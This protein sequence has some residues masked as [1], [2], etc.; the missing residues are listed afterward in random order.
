MHQTGYSRTEADDKNASMPHIIVKLGDKVVKNHPITQD[1]VSIGRARDNDIILEN[2][3]VSRNHA[4]IR[5]EGTQIVLVDLNSANGIFVNGVRVSRAEL[6]DGDIVSIGKHRLHFFEQ[7]Q[8][9]SVGPGAAIAADPALQSEAAPP[10]RSKRRK[11]VTAVPMGTPVPDLE[12]APAAAAP[13]ANETADADLFRRVEAGELIAV[14]EVK[15]GRQ[16]GEAFRL[17]IGECVIGRHNCAVRLHD[18]ATARQHARISMENPRFLL[19]D[20]GSWQGTTVNGE[21]VREKSLHPGDEIFVGTTTL[22]FAVGEEAEL[23]TRFTIHQPEPIMPSEPVSPRAAV[24]EPPASAPARPGE[25]EPEPAPAPEPEPAAESIVLAEEGD[26]ISVTGAFPAVAPEEEPDP[27]DDE[28]APMTDEELAELE[29]E[30]DEAFGGISEEELA[31][32]A[33]FEQLEAERLMQEGGG[34]DAVRTGALIDANEQLQ[35]E[36]DAGF[37]DDDVSFGVDDPALGGQTEIPGI[38]IEE[39]RSLF[40]GPVEAVEPGSKPSWEEETPPATKES[41]PPPSK[42]EE[43]P[44]TP[45]PAKEKDEES[46]FGNIPIPEGVDPKEVH[47]WIRGLKNKSKVVRREAARKLRELTGHEYDWESDP[48]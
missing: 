8:V 39:E 11:S 29:R 31:R 21:K 24:V 45:A 17:P 43:E 47:R 42:P 20:L 34:L 35:A 38:D 9:S 5:R 26:G 12:S 19:R 7:S 23:A 44:P 30:A 4:R 3:S 10:L 18:P 22:V 37:Q 2:L 15:H 28:F 48:E 33:E 40:N 27:F 13:A 41:T 16:A 6:V 14:L 25:P 1:V 32:Q 46:P 36:E